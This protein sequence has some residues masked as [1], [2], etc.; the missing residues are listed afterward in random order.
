[1]TAEKR[2]EL[3]LRSLQACQIAYGHLKAS[4]EGMDPTSMRAAKKYLHDAV[5]A[6]VL[7]VAEH[8]NP[9]D[10][11][12]M[13]KSNEQQKETLQEPAGSPAGNNQPA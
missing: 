10:P 13:T 9:L 1:M 8:E 12:T 7:L 4:S 3:H 2:R 5:L 11:S 6:C